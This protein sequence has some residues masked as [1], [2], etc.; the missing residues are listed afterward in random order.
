MLVDIDFLSS[1]AWTVH[2]SQGRGHPRGRQAGRS[3][4]GPAREPGHHHRHA[5][6]S[7]PRPRRDGDETEVAGIRRL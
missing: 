3:V 2:V 4:C 1:S 5:G 7:P 6:P